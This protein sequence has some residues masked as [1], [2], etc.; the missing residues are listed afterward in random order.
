[1]KVPE[2]PSLDVLQLPV[3][4]DNTVQDKLISLMYQVICDGETFDAATVMPR[5]EAELYAALYKG[6]AILTR[7]EF[8]EVL[9][10]A[11]DALR[12]KKDLVDFI[13]TIGVKK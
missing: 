7:A 11:V 13:A 4:E 8:G 2:L 9:L 12:V 5:V 1:L 6:K 3:D 10:E